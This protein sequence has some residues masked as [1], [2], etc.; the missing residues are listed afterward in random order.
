[1]E[2]QINGVR[3]WTLKI[4][5]GLAG[6]ALPVRLLSA[7]SW[8]Q[9]QDNGWS[10]RRSA[11]RAVTRCGPGRMLVGSIACSCGRHL[12][13]RCECGAVTYG[14][15]LGEGCRGEVPPALFGP[16]LRMRD[17]DTIDA[18]LRL[19]AAL[20]QA[21]RERVGPLPSIAV[22][23]ALVDERR[24]LTEW[25]SSSQCPHSCGH[26]G[27][28]IGRRQSCVPDGHPVRRRPEDEIQRR[29]VGPNQSGSVV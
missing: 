23:D 3:A 12:T 22:A 27:V 9:H 14:P 4:S 20:R 19:V 1:M 8:S 17:I 24:K 25:I 7:S 26:D 2:P 28:G 13:W 29:V 18:E 11:A 5:C 10:G 6:R 21:S 16:K 15:A